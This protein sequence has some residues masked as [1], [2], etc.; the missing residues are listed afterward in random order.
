MLT[1]LVTVF[2]F[3]VV[4]AS[5][6]HLPASARQLQAPSL[7]GP[8]GGFGVMQLK[9]HSMNKEEMDAIA[10]AQEKED[11]DL[12]YQHPRLKSI[13]GQGVITINLKS[14]DRLVHPSWWR[15]GHKHV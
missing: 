9:Y 1:L 12:L 2:F 3:V 4:K 7:A 13:A 5:T 14:V 8:D 15:G 10:E 6:A 11:M